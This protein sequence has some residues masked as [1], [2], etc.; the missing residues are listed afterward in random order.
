MEVEV[1]VEVAVEVEVEVAVE[2]VVEVE[3]VEVICMVVMVLF[4]QPGIWD[5]VGG[6][7]DFVLKALASARTPAFCNKCIQSILGCVPTPNFPLAG[8]IPLLVSG[9][10]LF[11][12]DVSDVVGWLACSVGISWPY[13]C[14]INI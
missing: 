11:R 13:S 1:E 6:V 2:V 9:S 4:H 5:L 3:V 10:P 7:K 12:N 8:C 14:A